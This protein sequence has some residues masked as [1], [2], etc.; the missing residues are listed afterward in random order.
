MRYFF[1]LKGQRHERFFENFS[2]S[3]LSIH[4]P[5]SRLLLV[6]AFHSQDFPHSKFP[7]VMVLNAEKQIVPWK[8]SANKDSKKGWINLGFWE[9]AHLPLPYANIITYFSLRAK[10]WGGVGGQ[11]PRNLN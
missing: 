2:K 1:R 11:F 5:E 8:G 6:L 4:I 9:T 7:N 3:L 10:C